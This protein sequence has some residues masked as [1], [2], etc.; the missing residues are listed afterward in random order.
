[1]RM[2]D[3]KNGVNS[4]V[5]ALFHHRVYHKPKRGSSIPEPTRI[6]DRKVFNLRFYLLCLI[7]PNEQG[8]EKNL[9]SFCIN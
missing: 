1:M 5:V 3:V 6:N 4:I 2:Y 8:S 9:K 7:V